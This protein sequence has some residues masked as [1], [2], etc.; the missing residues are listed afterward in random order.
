LDTYLVTVQAHL[1]MCSS[2]LIRT[3]FRVNGQDTATALTKSLDQIQALAAPEDVKTYWRALLYQE[4]RLWL[5][6]ADQMEMLA[7]LNPSS[8]S[9]IQMGD[10]YLKAGLLPLAEASYQRAL[11]LAR[12]DDDA[13]TQAT[14]LTGLGQVAYTAKSNAREASI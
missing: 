2:P 1:P 11:D 14:A 4:H 6:A 9:L 3:V 10:L 5:A 8:P 7:R 12:S 13:F